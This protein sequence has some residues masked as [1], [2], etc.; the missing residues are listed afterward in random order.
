MAEEVKKADPP[1]QPAPIPLRLTKKCP[2]KLCG[3]AVMIICGLA[4]VV[5][6]VYLIYHPKHPNYSVISL[7][8]DGFHRAGN[9]QILSPSI[10]I[11][12]RA[13]NHKKAQIYT[14]KSSVVVKVAYPDIQLWSG[15]LPVVGKPCKRITYFHTILQGSML[16]GASFAAIKEKQRKRKIPLKV[17]MTVPVKY[18]VWFIKSK[19]HN[20][21]VRCFVVVDDLSESPTMLYNKCYTSWV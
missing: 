12:M 10:D 18:N 13:D 16:S 8:F 15:A 3:L 1:E 2:R 9:N 6:L 7:R 11:I 20:L 21:D 17:E 19:T 4:L 14:S 5:F